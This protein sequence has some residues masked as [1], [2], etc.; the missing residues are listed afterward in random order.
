[1][2]FL[3]TAFPENIWNWINQADTWLFLQINTVLTH[4]F[5]D[6]VYPWYREG[7]AWVP[8]YLFMIIFALLNFSNRAYTWIL[9]IVITLI[10]TD[11][12]SSSWVKPFFERIRPCR[13]PELMGRVRLILNGC[14][15]GY[16]F[17]SSH[18]TNHFGFAVFVMMTL[19][20][21]IGK[22]KY[23][24]PVWAVTICYGQIY[25]GVHYPLDILGGAILGTF[26]GWLTAGFYLRKM[27]PITV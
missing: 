1:M 16:S 12:I 2:A 17:T 7:N 6:A 26:I 23:A 20:K 25:V 22:W 13:D 3:L 27:G 19:G 14:S 18:A 4:P 9:F 11:Q 5:L 8:L 24:F 10:L 21:V 15:G